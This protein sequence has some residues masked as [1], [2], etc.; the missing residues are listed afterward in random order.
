MPKININ[1]TQTKTKKTMKRHILI[2]GASANEN[3][4]E[5]SASSNQDILSALSENSIIAVVTEQKLKIFGFDV[6]GVLRSKCWQLPKDYSSVLDPEAFE[7]LKLAEAGK[8][9]KTHFKNAS[10]ELD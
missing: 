2:T 7:R 10:I 3:W 6:Q 4:Q 1:S 5:A 8:I 9:L